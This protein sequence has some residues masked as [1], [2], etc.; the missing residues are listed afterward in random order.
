MWWII[1][2]VV[3]VL[4]LIVFFVFSR[5]RSLPIFYASY[6][7]TMDETGSPEEA[8]RRT[9]SIFAERPPFDILT[10]HDIERLVTLF[11]P[12]PDPKVLGR[13]FL[14]L[15]K[16]GDASALKDADRVA[17]MVQIAAKHAAMD[18]S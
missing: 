13:I 12:L 5:V 11:A 8:L 1:G 10:E 14:E 6:N 2:G 16:M 3:A 4:V 15:D 9:V 7:A 18:K 17:E